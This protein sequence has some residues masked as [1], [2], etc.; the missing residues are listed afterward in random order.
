MRELRSIAIDDLVRRLSVSLS[1]G[2]TRLWCAKTT[3]RSEVPFGVKTLGGPRNIVSNG[4]PDP[5]STD[6][7]V[8]DEEVH[9][10]QP[11]PNYFGLLVCTH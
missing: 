4:G 9:S 3:E 8:G 11:L 1:H 6:H 7:G 2:F 5:I 10:M